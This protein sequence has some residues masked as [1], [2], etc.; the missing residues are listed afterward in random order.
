[1]II[2]KTIA[3]FPFPPLSPIKFANKILLE[4]LWTWSHNLFARLPDLMATHTWQ[5]HVTQSHD[6]A[7][8]TLECARTCIHTCTYWLGSCI[9]NVTNIILYTWESHNSR[10]DILFVYLC[11]CVC[12]CVWA[13]RL[14]RL[15]HAMHWC[16]WVISRSYMEGT[17]DALQVVMHHH[18]SHFTLLHHHTITLHTSYL[19]KQAHTHSHTD[20][21]TTQQWSI[22]NMV[23]TS[24]K[25]A[26]S[27]HV[28]CT[29]Y[30]VYTYIWKWSQ[31][32]ITELY[33]A[34]T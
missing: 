9:H 22:A 26:L 11:L 19:H 6:P 7:H 16:D 29:I 20:R 5:V 30:Y 33:T 23:T 3:N 28:T 25:Y 17:T 8:T 18:T 13:S 27:L 14:A 2:R 31:T 12:V 10:R 4:T 24:Y 32:L 34:I 1:M 21:H 15:L